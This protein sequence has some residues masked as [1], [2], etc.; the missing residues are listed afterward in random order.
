MR[1]AEWGDSSR[2]SFCPGRIAHACQVIVSSCQT[3]RY[4]HWWTKVLPCCPYATVPLPA[5]MFSYYRRVRLFSIGWMMFFFLGGNTAVRLTCLNI[6]ASLSTFILTRWASVSGE[7]EG[8]CISLQSH[9]CL[10][11]CFRIR[12]CFCVGRPV[13]NYSW[14]SSWLG[15][16]TNL[17]YLL[18]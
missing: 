18:S 4:P 6:I 17:S 5:R 14:A 1:R 10:L 2:P 12:F 16:S 7:H 11:F 13:P 3:W 15:K 8:P 9:F